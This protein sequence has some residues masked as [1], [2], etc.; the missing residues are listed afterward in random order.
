LFNTKNILLG[1]R[2]H[3]TGHMTYVIKQKNKLYIK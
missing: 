2:N 3:D 1:K